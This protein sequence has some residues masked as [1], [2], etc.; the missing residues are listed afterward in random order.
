[1]QLLRS[2]IFNAV[3]FGACFGLTLWLRLTASLD[4]DGEYIFSKGQLWARI[5][6]RALKRWCG[7]DVALHGAEFLPKSGPALI[8]PQHQSAFDIMI[9]LTVLPRPVYVLKVELLRI[10]LFGPLLSASGFVAVDRAGGT[11]ALRKM[12][13]E[14]REA[15]A[16]G[17]QIVI[18]PE[19]T[20]VPAGQRGTVQPGVL[21][22][23]RALNLPV[24]PAA[25]DSGR[26]WGKAA[27][28]KHPGTITVTVH[29]PIPVAEQRT[30]LRELERI[31]Y[32]ANEASPTPTSAV[33]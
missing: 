13:A 24:I 21:A 26:Y 31:F 12:V 2:A 8:A 11:Q 15:V 7:I 4:R 3:M 33:Q 6:L 20:R 25:T 17:H 9:W 19:G 18:F 14:C 22:L 27:F 10:P 23:A 5:T 28:R 32:H 16:R 30:L 1:M 29:P